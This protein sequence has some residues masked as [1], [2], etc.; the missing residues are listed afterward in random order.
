MTISREQIHHVAQLARLK[1]DPA[2]VDKFVDQVGDVLKYVEKLDAV[3]TRGVQPTSHAISL[4]NAFRE[5]VPGT[6]L[7]NQDA[8]ANAPQGENGEFIVPRVIG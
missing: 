7:K 4:S 6:H 8:L 1:L 5:D 2:A 3:D